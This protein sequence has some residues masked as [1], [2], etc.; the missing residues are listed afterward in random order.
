M[1]GMINTFIQ[2][3]GAETSLTKKFS[4]SLEVLQSEIGCL[5]NPL[6]AKLCCNT[7]LDKKPLGKIA[8]LPLQ[9]LLS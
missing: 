1:I 5:I 3:Y 8:L 2:H 7:V 9:N 4:A 6:K